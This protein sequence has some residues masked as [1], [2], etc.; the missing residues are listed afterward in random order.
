M[1]TELGF[2]VG[3]IDQAVPSQCSANVW[4]VVLEPFPNPVAQQSALLTQSTPLNAFDVDSLGSGVETMDHAV[5][6]QCSAN[7]FPSNGPSPTEPTAQQSAVVTQL[8]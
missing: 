5:P 6:F 8:T 2:G 1:L 3:T 7:V 4:S